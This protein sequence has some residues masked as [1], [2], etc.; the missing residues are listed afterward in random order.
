MA[1]NLFAY[2][3]CVHAIAG[4]VGSV[5]AMTTFYPLDT[6][7]FRKQIEDTNSDDCS[8]YTA[9]RRLLQTEGLAGLYAGIKPV[10]ISLGTSNFVY[11]YT[12]HGLKSMLNS[13]VKNDLVL[14]LLAG[15]TNVLLTTPLW[16]VNSRLKVNKKV[17]YTGLLEGLV[18]ISRTE[19]VQALWSGVY[20]SLMLVINPA[21]QFA[22]YEALKRRVSPKTAATVFMIGATAKAVSTVI[23]YPLQL[24]QTRQRY[25]K[26][27]KMNMLALLL[28]IAKK[29]GPQGLFQGLEAKLWQTVLTAALMF[30][31][32]E[33]VF[34]F[35][36]M[37]LMQ[38]RIVK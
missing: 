29:G 19:G 10:L 36:V 38:K 14:G 5:V 7:R 24:A 33:K 17:P 18:H 37:L 31:A 27:G 26:E 3:T 2:E 25:G 30:V 20:P 15:V 12:F 8:T 21:L 35:V 34:R 9:L 22:V 11:F 23:T 1:R 16:V 13:S 32:Y 6:V 4:S 28:A